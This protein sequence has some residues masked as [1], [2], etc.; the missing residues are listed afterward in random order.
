M[1][2]LGLNVYKNAYIGEHN[3]QNCI[4][5]QENYFEEGVYQKTFA[6][7]WWRIFMVER[8][9][10]IAVELWVTEIKTGKVRNWE[11][12]DLSDFP[13]P[14]LSCEELWRS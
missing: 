2:T 14:T 9:L 11:K 10:Q 4:T 6:L 1:S 12:S 7:K 13:I 8:K 3:I 5:L